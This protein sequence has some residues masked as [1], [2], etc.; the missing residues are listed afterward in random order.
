M[1]CMVGAQTM[2]AE[3][4]MW[5]INEILADFDAVSLYPS[6]MKRLGGYLKGRPKVLENRSY[7]F[8]KKQDGY[9]V[10]NK[11]LK[12]GKKF[13]FPQMSYKNENDVRVWTNEPKQNLFVCKCQLEDLIEFHKIEFEVIDGYYY[14]EGRNMKLESV[15][16]FVFNE[17]LK[18][19]K[20]GNTPEQIYKLIMNSAYGKTMLKPFMDKTVFVAGKE[21]LDK[22]IDKHYN[23]ML[24][25]ESLYGST[26]TFQRYKAKI[27]Q[28]INEHFNNAHCGVEIL[29]MSML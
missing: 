18:L 21:N 14:D 1:K 10:Q 16:E 5:H 26:E 13:K 27:E 7:A 8:L 3:N 4:K 11:I 24:N 17:R 6:A 28:G 29:A 9:S 22:F 19:K 23:R 20:E 25:F 12:V 15:I 2:T